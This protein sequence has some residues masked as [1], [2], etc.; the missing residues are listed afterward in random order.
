MMKLAVST[1]SLS[2]WQPGKKISLERKIDRIAEFGVRGVEFADA[3]IKTVRRAEALRNHARKRGLDVVGYCV[4]AELLAPQAKQRAAVKQLKHEVD[5]AAALGCRGMRHDVTRG[6]DAYKRYPGPKTFAAALRHIVPAIREVADYAAQ[7]NVTTT[8]ENHGFY[9]QASKRVVQ[10][11]ETVN[12]PHF[13]LTMDMGNFLC[14]NENPVDAVR[15]AAKHAVLIHTKDF[16]VRPKKDMPLPGWFATPTQIALR[17]AIVGHGAIDIAA[18]LR[19]VKRTGYRGYL[20]LEFEGIE[21]PT[22]AIEQGLNF[23]RRKLKKL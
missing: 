5:I 16:H 17:G 19:A 4:G 11:I 3:E 10:L 2:R 21:E 13:A 6:F 15:R 23:L 20:S 7:R 12:H 8:L 18:Q 22:F 1:Y 14:V 9:M